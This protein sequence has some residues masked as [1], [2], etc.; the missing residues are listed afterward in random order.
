MNEYSKN[1][2]EEADKLNQKAFKMLQTPNFMPLPPTTVETNTGI[3]EAN[4]Q[5]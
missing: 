5:G 3:C 2:S 1:D 4:S